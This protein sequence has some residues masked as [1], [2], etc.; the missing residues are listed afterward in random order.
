MKIFRIILKF[1]NISNES[2]G[3][4]NFGDPATGVNNTSTDLSPFH[5]FSI[6]G[7]ILLQP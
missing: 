7:S 1:F 4:W 5:D 3:V 6:D 2:S